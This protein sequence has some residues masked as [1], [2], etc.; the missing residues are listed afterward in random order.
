MRELTKPS[1]PVAAGDDT[2]VDWDHLEEPASPEDQAKA[3]EWLADVGYIPLAAKGIARAGWQMLREYLQELPSPRVEDLES[4]VIARNHRSRPFIPEEPTA[5]IQVGEFSEVEEYALINPRRI[6]ASRP[7]DEWIIHDVSDASR[8]ADIEDYQPVPVSARGVAEFARRIAREKGDGDGLRELFSGG[9]ID[10]VGHQLPPGA[11]F[12]IEGNGNHRLAALT[13]LEVP[14]VLAHTRWVPGLYRSAATTDEQKRYRRMLNAAH[15]TQEIDL[16]LYVDAHTEWPILLCGGESAIDSLNAYE[17]I[18][19]H[20]I[21][22]PIGRLA[23][24]QF[25][26]LHQLDKLTRRVNRRLTRLFPAS[27]EQRE[28]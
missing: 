23:R 28:G 10:V 4:L 27:K 26:D 15:V 18:L 12:I 5:W 21:T 9:G 22:E 25:R 19:G 13:A 2:G 24:N 16:P 11:L 14:C 6:L 1:D 7:G 20:P 17:E 3:R 8:R